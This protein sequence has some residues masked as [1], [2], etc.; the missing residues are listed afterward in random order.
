M[1]LYQLAPVSPSLSIA[2]NVRRFAATSCSLLHQWCTVDN[3]IFYMAKVN[4]K[5]LHVTGEMNKSVRHSCQIFA[6][7]N[8]PKI[9]KI[10]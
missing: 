3:E 6:G 5:W 10:G 7:F 2:D 4:V 9:I 1:P 8:K